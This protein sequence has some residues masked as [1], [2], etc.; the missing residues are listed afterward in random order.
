MALG[1]RQFG[2]L[3]A[4]AGTFGQL[5]FAKDGTFTGAFTVA[6]ADAAC[7]KPVVAQVSGIRALLFDRNNNLVRTRPVFPYPTV[8]RYLGSGD[9]NVAANFGAFTPKREPDVSLSFIGDYL[10]APGYPQERCHAEGAQLVC[11]DNGQ[12][13]D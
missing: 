4:P 3:P 6:C 5:S 9:P 1:G 2:V 10:F 11:S 12:H 13:D 8:A 7:T